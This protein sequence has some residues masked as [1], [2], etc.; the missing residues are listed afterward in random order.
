M[1]LINDYKNSSKREIWIEGVLSNF[2]YGMLGAIVVVAV[3]LRLDIGVLIAY[4]AY[5]FYLGRVVNRPRY[6][7]S[8]GKFVV[9]PIP[10][11]IGA[12]VGYKLSPIL[13]TLIIL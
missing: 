11:A 5:Y 9:F 12:F 10:T 13:I 4:L 1:G 6:V 7:T 2:I 3:T 8:L